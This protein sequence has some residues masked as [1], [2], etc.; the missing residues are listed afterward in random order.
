MFFRKR[1]E[2]DDADEIF[3]GESPVQE[4]E[5][6]DKKKLLEGLKKLDQFEEG[7]E[8]APIE[9]ELTSTFETLS[10]QNDIDKLK[11]ERASLQKEI[12]ELR[13]KEEGIRKNIAETARQLNRMIRIKRALEE[14]IKELKGELDT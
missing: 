6:E 1:R 8:E 4:E 5:V 9:E 14:K 2:E 12:E 11:E 13:L 7:E 10:V 3:E